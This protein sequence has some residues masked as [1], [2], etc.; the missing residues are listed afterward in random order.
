MKIPEIVVK[1]MPNGCVCLETTATG[2][3]AQATE[4]PWDA[5]EGPCGSW[6]PH[7]DVKGLSGEKAWVTLW[8]TA[9]TR[10][11]GSLRVVEPEGKGDTGA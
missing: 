11:F 6:C 9:R 7:F 5:N 10:D 1:V 3:G 8:C 2:P 4:C